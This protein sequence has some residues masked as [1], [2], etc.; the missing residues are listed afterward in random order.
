MATPAAASTFLH[1]LGPAGRAVLEAYAAHRPLCAF[2]VDGT[3]APIV[4]RPEDAAIPDALKEALQRLAAVAPVAILTGRAVNDARAM[5]GFAPAHVLG[6]H[7]IE[8]LPGFEDRARVLEETCTRWHARLGQDAG[9]RDAQVLLE[10]KRY[11][12]SLHYRNAPDWAAA[13][14]AIDDAVAALDPR[15]HLIPGKCVVNVLPPG[16]L[17]KGQALA[18]LLDVTGMAHALYAGDDDTDEHVFDLPRERVLGLRVG[19]RPESNASL[20]V[21][22]PGEM[23]TVVELLHA[24]WPDRRG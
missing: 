7:G 2:D 17:T 19:A 3:L 10:D 15:P 23:L 21:D 13:Q 12:L 18:H 20:F 22:H 9:L 14:R 4:S 16:A 24:A 1:A 5:L 11:S 8:G 6:N